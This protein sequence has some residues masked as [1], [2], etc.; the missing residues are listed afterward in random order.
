M[1][2]CNFT[3]FE[4]SYWTS[5]AK[6]P[7]PLRDDKMSFTLE[8]GVLRYSVRGRLV[9]NLPAIEETSNPIIRITLFPIECKG[10]W[11]REITKVG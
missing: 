7:I 8:D 3:T 9:P 1:T 2:F 11:V 4:V 5:Q 10:T 6:L